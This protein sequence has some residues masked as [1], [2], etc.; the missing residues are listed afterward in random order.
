MD[1]RIRTLQQEAEKL[2]AAYEAALPVQEKAKQDETSKSSALAAAQ[3]AF[4]AAEQANSASSQTLGS[5]LQQKPDLHDRLRDAEAALTGARGKVRRL[6]GTGLGAEETEPPPAASAPEEGAGASDDT[7]QDPGAAA[8]GLK[9]LTARELDGAQDEPT[10]SGGAPC[11]GAGS[12][13]A[14]HR[15]GRR[16]RHAPSG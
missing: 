13:P 6:G 10:A 12:D 1:P 16:G 15:R 14:A 8:D 11:S 3:A 4:D 2:Q 9:Q 5:V 7:E